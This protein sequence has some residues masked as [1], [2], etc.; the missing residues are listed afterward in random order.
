MV[1]PLAG[2]VP[3]R[4][5]DTIPPHAEVIE[6]RVPELAR[7]FNAI[8]PSPLYEKDLDADA[9]EF[10]V[11]WA[12]EAPGGARLALL[13]HIDRATPLPHEEA[14]ARDSIHAFFGNRAGRLRRQLRTLF[15]LGRTSLMI[16]I[17]ALAGFIAVGDLVFWASGGGRMGEVVRE[18]L[19]I[20]GWV[21]M[22]RPLEIFLYDW[23]PI[24]AEIRLFDRLAVMPI[25][26]RQTGDGPR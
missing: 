17:A 3:D 4:S 19:M 11:G 16:G 15:R 8:D 12:R 5:G 20:G 21:A 7:L 24:R 14:L 1:Q 13:V 2:P 25:R 18:S 6:V 10:I 22:W 23:W 9:E 26:I